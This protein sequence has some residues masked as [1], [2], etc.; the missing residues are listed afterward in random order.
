MQLFTKTIFAVLLFIFLFLPSISFSEFKIESLDVLFYNI[1]KD[2]SVTVTESIKFM[3]IGDYEKKLYISGFDK[4]DLSF[5]ATSTR[6][7]DMK[8]HVNDA[9]VD[10]KELTVTPQTLK[11]C[12]IMFNRCR[13]EII[14]NYIASPYYNKTTGKALA[15]TGI[16]TIENPKP[17]TV[18]YSL[19]PAAL[20]FTTTQEGDILLDK[21]VILSIQLPENSAVY[22]ISPEP[23]NY[24]KDMK[25]LQW[26]NMMLVH[27]SLIF[28]VEYSISM[29]VAEFFSLVFKSVESIISGPQGIAIVII[30]IIL[31]A[32]YIYLKSI[33]RSKK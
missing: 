4:N 11:D 19:N 27:F 20:A 5:W 16:F 24:A 10:V 32:A 17:R 15:K 6:L 1:Q 30:I 25:L 8:K 26:S 18:G 3:V 22:K 14:I 2:G 7:T 28:E 9:I 23:E 13:G 33:R 21:H 31:L 29:E 12:S